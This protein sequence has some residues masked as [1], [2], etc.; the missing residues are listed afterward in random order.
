[1]SPSDAASASADPGTSTVRTTRQRTAVVNALASLEDFRSAQQLHDLL[2]HQGEQVGLT[3]VYRTLQLL[4]E[5]GEV[6]VIVGD[7]GESVY[8]QCSTDHHHHLVCR[9]CGAAIEIEGPEVERWATQ[10]AARHAY[11]D[12]SHRI[13]IFGRCPAC[14]TP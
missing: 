11:T 10:I 9:D 6:D 14:A 2:R 7:D 1:M 5:R 4:A 3:T 13:E 8:R 12:V